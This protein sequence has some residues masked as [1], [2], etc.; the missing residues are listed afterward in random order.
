MLPMHR[1]EKLPGLAGMAFF[2][3]LRS[4]ITF[5]EN[6][7]FSWMFLGLNSSGHKNASQHYRN[8]TLE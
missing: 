6:L 3:G 2:T 8:Y 1:S 4:L 5:F 7:L